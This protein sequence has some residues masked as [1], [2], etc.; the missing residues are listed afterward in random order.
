[1]STTRDPVIGCGCLFAALQS[2]YLGEPSQQ[3][4]DRSRTWSTIDDQ[5]SGYRS[6]FSGRIGTHTIR[7][8]ALAPAST[9]S[10]MCQMHGRDR[11]RPGCP[12]TQAIEYPTSTHPRECVRRPSSTSPAQMPE[13]ARIPVRFSTGEIQ[14]EN[15]RPECSRPVSTN[16][17][18]YSP[19]S[20][21]D[22]LG[23]LSRSGSSKVK[24]EKS[25]KCHRPNVPNFDSAPRT[26]SVSIIAPCTRVRRN[27]GRRPRQT[28]PD[29]L[30]SSN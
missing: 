25:G 13:C 3:S 8:F 20:I 16:C 22:R 23:A 17:I 27:S 24:H 18:V 28:A 26:S 10:I 14:Y 29:N 30:R 9:L 19:A 5:S 11:S 7:S 1:M 12:A 2:G 21:R 4:P 6:R 15:G